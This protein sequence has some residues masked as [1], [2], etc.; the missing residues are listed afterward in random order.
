MTLTSLLRLLLVFTATAA[1]ASPTMGRRQ[2]RTQPACR[3]PKCK[4][5]VSIPPSSIGTGCVTFA[6][7]HYPERYKT[8]DLSDPVVWN[9]IEKEL[10]MFNRWTVKECEKLKADKMCLFASVKLVDL[11]WD[12]WRGRGCPEG[13]EVVMI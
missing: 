6:T 1:N 7:T 4:V 12:R 5:S 3:I 11:D 8:M 9:L 13:V 10:V 2:A